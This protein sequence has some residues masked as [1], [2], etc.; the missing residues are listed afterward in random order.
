M[1][2]RNSK[3]LK[4]EVPKGQDSHSEDS[5]RGINDDLENLRKLINF[6]LMFGCGP[7]VG[8]RGDTKMCQDFSQAM[9]DGLNDHM[10][11]EFPLFMESIRASD[12]NFELITSA[13][14]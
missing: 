10:Y 4:L 5:H 6:A 9:L 2:A 12:A 14:L 8:V 13:T 11:S 1:T 3:L 7:S